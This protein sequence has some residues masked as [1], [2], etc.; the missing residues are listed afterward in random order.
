MTAS[1]MIVDFGCLCLVPCIPL[2]SQVVLEESDRQLEDHRHEQVDTATLQ[3]RKVILHDFL[4]VVFVKHML[5][6]NSSSLHKFH[7][8]LLSLKILCWFVT[9]KHQIWHGC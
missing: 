4:A 8:D 3:C 2:L 5:D 1:V 7:L 9:C 6:A